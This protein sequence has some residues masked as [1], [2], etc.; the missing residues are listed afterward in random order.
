MEPSIYRYILKHTL[1]D[2]VLILL[3]TLVSFPIVY[4][5]LEVPKHIINSAINGKNIP[6]TIMGYPL[7]QFD[8]LFFLSGLFLLLV[9]INGAIKYVLNVYRGIVGERMLRDLRL[10]LFSRILRFP[11]PHF[12]KVSQGE[13]IPIVTAE[14]EPLG[15]FIG[16]AFALPAFQGGLLLTYLFFIFNQDALLGVAAV[17]LYPFQMWV[18]P[19]LQAKVNQ[20]GKQRVLAARRLGD[21]VGDSI[22]GIQEIHAF[23]VA[24]RE[25]SNVLERVQHIFMIR[26][27]I[28]KL[29]FF[30]KFLNNFLSKVTPFFFYSAGGY[31][32]IKGELSLG[33][34]IA[35]L[36]AY[37]DL[38]APWKELLKFYQTK[39]DVRIKYE[40][41]IEQFHPEGLLPE[42][43]QT[44]KAELLPVE[45]LSLTARNVS[46]AEYSNVN[47]VNNLSIELLP[48]QHTAIVGPE[49]SG[50]TELA[51]LL[52][53]L[54]QPKT[55]RIELAGQNIQLLNERTLSK[56]VAYVGAHAHFFAGTIRENL[57]YGVDPEFASE[58][59][60][61][62]YQ[63]ENDVMELLAEVQLQDDVYHYGLQSYI[64]PERDPDLA[65]EVLELRH[66]LRASLHAA[67]MDDL[68][69]FFD[70]DKYNENLSVAENLL[71]GSSRTISLDFNK[72]ARHPLIHQSLKEVDLMGEALRVGYE[73]AKIMVELFADVEPG[74]DLFERFSF[75]KSEELPEYKQLLTKTSLDSLMKLP[76][77][78]QE[79]L[80]VLLF[81]L[82]PARHRLG[83]LTESRK[84]KLLLV[85][86]KL[87]L[88]LQKEAHDLQLYDANEYNAAL[89]L[90][91]NI[92][93]GKIV[94]GQ[95]RA[96][97]EIS[98]RIDEL[99]REYELRTQIMCYGLDFSVGTSGSRLSVATRQKLALVRALLKKPSFLIVNQATSVL[100]LGAERH[101]I[102]C[103][104]KRM[105]G[106]GVC[107]I[108][109]RI[110]QTSAFDYV[111]VMEKGHVVD[112]GEYTKLKD[113]SQAFQ[114]LLMGGVE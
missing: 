88:A 44:G 40:Q 23:G 4:A 3:L 74:S 99:V 101:I 38:D 84:T 46:Y 98:Q 10:E 64:D 110:E 57:Y 9:V 18:I 68:V 111:L 80:L 29:K 11:I 34:L 109:G 104:L 52:S 16:E 39:E 35:V 108:L 53:R 95:A 105:K 50:K 89:T 83:L 62:Q 24:E 19:K 17:A 94:Y 72:L 26:L 76:L 100:D 41:I 42:A 81:Q 13:I 8:Y 65:A 93:F 79:M 82:V 30:I 67:E 87:F 92:L 56:H 12:K 113:N 77:A 43:L 1:K 78:Q 63:V 21:R 7:D 70:W 54:L 75:I 55:G 51:K 37:Q 14:T 15:G 33:A 45:Q 49:G 2:Q 31:Y 58:N 96:Q 106:Q 32:V 97:T 90:Q 36:S 27:R 66:A 107:W 103:V 85:R 47:I 91:E 25:R 61:C 5:S 69:E 86:K 28:Y 114:A 60:S 20:L 48:Q 71:F 22:A 112:Q 102:H 73:L 59:T 6:D